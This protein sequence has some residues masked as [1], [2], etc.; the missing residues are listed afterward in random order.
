MVIIKKILHDGG[1]KRWNGV[2][3]AIVKILGR[4]ETTNFIVGIV[5][6]SLH[7]SGMK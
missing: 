4:S 6:W 5:L 2:R 7:W 1:V 3:I